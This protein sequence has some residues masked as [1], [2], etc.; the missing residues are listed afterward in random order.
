MKVVLLIIPVHNRIED[1]KSLLASLCRLEKNG[2]EL[3]VAIVDDGS[4]YPVRP[5]VEAGFKQLKIHFFRNEVSKGPS[6]CR[7]LAACAIESDYIWF[8]DS[9][10]EI[11]D[12]CVLVEMTQRLNSNKRVGAVGGV[13][14]EHND[15]RKI[16]ETD[17]LKN[18]IFLDRPFPPHEYKPSYVDGISTSN[19]FLRRGVFE[20]TRGFREELLR[21]EDNDLCLTLRSLGYQ[22][23]QDT[24]T[25]V[26]HKVSDRGRRSGTFAH[27]ADQRWYLRDLLKTRSILLAHHAPWCLPIL[28]MLDVVLA[29]I[30]LYRIKRGTYTISRFKKTVSKSYSNKIPFFIMTYAG[31]YLW[32]LRLFLCK[33]FDFSN[34]KIV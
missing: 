11:V 8:L 31:T 14:E 26:W 16:M 25:T 13:F 32:G 20:S 27:F 9:D 1:L 4:F 23:Y 17:I 6:F 24:E 19:L 15:K 33:V 2:I 21:D 10:S 30:I 7:N 22:L 34:S 29:P 3:F 12:P 5:E 18:F 28:P